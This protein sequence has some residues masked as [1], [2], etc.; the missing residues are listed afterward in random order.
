VHPIESL[1]VQVIQPVR[2]LNRQGGG[3][4]AYFG[5][6]AFDPSAGEDR[7]KEARVADI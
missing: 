5:Q 6:L 3:V 2:E 4:V 1:K 7:F